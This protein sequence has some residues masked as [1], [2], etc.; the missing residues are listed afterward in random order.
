MALPP[1]EGLDPRSEALDAWPVAALMASLWEGQLAAVAAVGPALEA[2]A[3]AAEAAVARLRAHDAGRLVYAGAGSSARLGAQDGAELAPT[4]SWPAERLLLLPAGG[5]GALTRA[6]E[7][8]EDDAAAGRD[9]AVAHAVGAGDVVIGLAASGA[10]PFTCAAVEA[11]RAAGALTVGISNAPGGRLLVVAE[12]AVLLATGAEAIAGSTRMKAGTAQKVALNLLSTAIMV[13]LGRTYRGRMVAM[14]AT[15]A[16]LQGRAVRMVAELAAVDAGAAEAALARADG[17]VEVAVV[18][19]ALG[20]G[21]AE[22][23]ERLA[24]A[25]GVL[26][27]ALAERWN[28]P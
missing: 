16:K 4:F 5:V 24:R 15:N 27:A 14:R 3:G 11:A 1:T 6:I 20:L 22:A 10:T 21:V 8:A 19:A 26:R 18:V 13:G 17:R 23:E 12:H 7:G 9:A 25:G 2:L 28:R